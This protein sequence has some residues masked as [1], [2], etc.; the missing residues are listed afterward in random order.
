M[1][2][3]LIVR[4]TCDACKKETKQRYLIKFGV[5]DWDDENAM[6]NII[7]KDLCESCYNDLLSLI[8]GIEK[9]ETKR[10]VSEPTGAPLVHGKLQYD[11]DK[12]IE[13]Y[14]AGCSFK[15]IGQRLNLTYNQIVSQTRILRAEG[16]KKGAVKKMGNPELDKPRMVTVVDKDGLVVDTKMV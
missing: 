7:S 15:E 14:E 10:K 5:G 9:V 8:G 4:C 6:T 1:A 13:M 3:E 16:Y 11:K 2:K 12:L